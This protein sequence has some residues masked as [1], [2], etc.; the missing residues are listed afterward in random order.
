[1]GDQLTYAGAGI[2]CRLCQLAGQSGR[3]GGADAHH[4]S[5]LDLTGLNP[6]AAAP[7]TTTKHE[8]IDLTRP[9]IDRWL[10]TEITF[11]EPG[12]SRQELVEA[13]ELTRRFSRSTGQ[14]ASMNVVCKALA[15][16]GCTVKRRLVLSNGSRR[17]FYAIWRP[18][19][20]AGRDTAEW[21]VEVERLTPSMFS[22][23]ER[24][25][26]CTALPDSLIC[27]GVHSSIRY[28]Q[29][30]GQRGWVVLETTNCG[31]AHAQ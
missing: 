26:P 3:A 24:C 12:I 23:V 19:Y 11:E 16:L 28:H 4:L 6:K 25:E 13:T 8:M 21:K 5:T 2:L 7:M 20:W 27:T 29:R 30:L 31:E 9:D 22:L 1:M 18:A 14:S 17:T 10:E 15:R